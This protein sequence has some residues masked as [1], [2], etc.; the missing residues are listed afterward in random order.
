MYMYSRMHMKIEYLP[1]VVMQVVMDRGCEEI[2]MYSSICTRNRVL[3]C[4][5]CAGSD[6]QGEIYNVHVYM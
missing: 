3:T 1:A 6:G 4:C 5:G 2:Y